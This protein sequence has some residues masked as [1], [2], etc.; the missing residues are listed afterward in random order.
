[1]MGAG[2]LNEAGDNP[3]KCPHSDERHAPPYWGC[4]EQGRVGFG[5]AIDGSRPSPEPLGPAKS[6]RTGQPEW[7]RGWNGRHPM[8]EVYHP[9]PEL[10]MDG[11][12]RFKGEWPSFSALALLVVVAAVMAGVVL[13]LKDDEGS[14][15][16]SAF[17]PPEH[18]NRAAAIAIATPESKL[19]CPEAEGTVFTDQGMEKRSKHSRYEQ[20]PRYDIEN[21]EKESMPACIA[22]CAEVDKCVAANWYNA[23]PQ[24]PISTT[25]G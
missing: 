11:A 13:W 23:G 7:A 10:E 24:G 18:N 21:R 19:E 4:S 15:Y 20:Y 22:W 8:L 25:A 12:P 17:P 2:P 1:M 16:T 5:V 9:A 14:G 3:F 6:S